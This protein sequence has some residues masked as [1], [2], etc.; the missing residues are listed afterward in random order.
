M[1]R[2]KQKPHDVDRLTRR[3]WS[4]QG[5]QRKEVGRSKTGTGQF[6][7]FSRLSARMVEVS[8]QQAQRDLTLQGT[9]PNKVA[10]GTWPFLGTSIDGQKFAQAPLDNAGIAGAV[11]GKAAVNAIEQLNPQPALR[12]PRE[13][14]SPNFAVLYSWTTVMIRGITN[15]WS[16]SAATGNLRRYWKLVKKDHLVSIFRSRIL[17]YL[18]LAMQ[19]TDHTRQRTA[20]LIGYWSRRSA[21]TFQFLTDRISARVKTLVHSKPLQR[22]KHACPNPRML[23]ARVPA[24]CAVIKNRFASVRGY[25]CTDCGRKVGFRSRPHNL[26]ERYIL[27]LFLTQPVRCAECFRRD[28]RLIFTPVREPSPHHDETADH[29]H[30]NAA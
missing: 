28:Y 15:Y 12:R 13:W 6:A 27:P 24:V 8:L 4:W 9:V 21:R 19:H 16:G 20:L 10:P 26:T 5:T 17:G 3:V 14:R 18:I 1:L 25:R 30:R 7:E 23:I 29:I 2:R 22:L 11:A